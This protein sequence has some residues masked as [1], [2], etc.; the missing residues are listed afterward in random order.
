MNIVVCEDNKKY[1][2]YINR[3]LTQHIGENKYNSQIVISTSNPNKVV[4]YAISNSEITAYFL[5]IKLS[6]SIS[7]IDLAAEIRKSDYLSPIVFITS[8]REM[9]SLTYEYKL[10]AMDYIIK[11]NDAKDKKKICDCL[12]LA[13]KR[14]LQGYGKCLNISDKTNSISIPFDEIY[15]IES[16]KS[17]HKITIFYENGMITMHAIMKEIET[18]LDERFIRCHRS[19]IVNKNK[20]IRVD[21]STHMLELIN[22]CH[23]AYSAK[24]KE[25]SEHAQ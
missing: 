14:Q 21:K 15:Y 16:I 22:G 11:S 18:K 8:H 20:I 19:F 2:D 17:S 3:I 25:V 10:E 24:Y 23:C 4:E 1:L 5:D 12:D 6:S 7:G 13:Q 9:M